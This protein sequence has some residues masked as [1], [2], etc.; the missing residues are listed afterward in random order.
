VPRDGR[1]TF[2]VSS[3]GAVVVD[4]AR[5]LAGFGCDVAPSCCFGLAG[6]AR[7]VLVAEVLLHDAAESTLIPVPPLA[8]GSGCPVLFLEGLNCFGEHSLLDEDSVLGELCEHEALC[9]LEPLAL[10]WLLLALMQ[11]LDES[12]DAV[13]GLFVVLL[14]EV[15]GVLDVADSVLAALELEEEVVVLA[16]EGVLVPLVAFEEELELLLVRFVEQVEMLLDCRVG[17]PLLF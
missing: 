10:L 15:D 13:E 11:V 2:E 4:A 5:T 9:L 8:T 6:E 1:G 12:L 14:T 16:F 17:A 3:F 7:E